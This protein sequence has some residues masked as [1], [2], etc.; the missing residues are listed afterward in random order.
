MAGRRIRAAVAAMLGAGL[1][2]LALTVGLASAHTVSLFI[3]SGKSIS[4][5][6]TTFINNHGN[7]ATGIYESGEE[8]P[9]H[10]SG[11]IAGAD[12]HQQDG[13]LIVFDDGYAYAGNSFEYFQGMLSQFTGSGVP[14]PFTAL[15]QNVNAIVDIPGYTGAIAVDNSGTSTNGNIYIHT[16]DNLV[17]AYDP[18][19]TPLA[20]NFPINFG[21]ESVSGLAVAPD[22]KIWVAIR[23]SSKVV[24]FT[25]GGAPTGVEVN[26]AFSP[27][28]IET[29]GSGNLYVTA[30][31]FGDTVKF[32]SAGT[33]LFKV[34]T[35][36]FSSSVGVDPANGN[37]YIAHGNTISAYKSDGAFIS[38]FGGPDPDHGFN[39]SGNI[40]DIAVN[41]S[42]HSIYVV[43][44][45]G[46]IHIF[47]GTGEI[48]VPDVTTGGAEVTP[49]TATV[50]GTI[51]PDGLDTTD[52]H[53][54]YGPST[55]YNE[56]A[57][58]CIEGKVLSGTGDV[59]V[60]AVLEDLTP[61]T[62]YHYR[63]VSNN[64]NGVTTPGP[65]QTFKPLGPPFISNETVSKVNTDNATLGTEI[66]PR[67]LATTYHFEIGTDTSYG[68]NLPEPD[69][70]LASVSDTER[71][72]QI[73][74]STE[75]TRLKPDTT[76]HFRVVATNEQG[77][78]EGLDHTFHTFPSAEETTDDCPNAHERQQTSAGLLL[79]C[80][81]YEIVSARN[82]GGYDVQSDVILGQGVLTARPD[83]KD[84]VLY[85]LH[86][87]KVPGVSGGPT[88]F[89]L[90]PY[91]A[92]RGSNGWT[93][94]YVG[95]PADETPGAKPFGSPLSGSDEDLNAFA[96]GGPG[97][98]SPCF[99]DGST[100]IPIRM[101]GGGLVQGMK[102]SLDP[103][104]GATQAGFIGQRLSDDGT[105]LVFGSTSKFEEGATAGDVTIYD[106]DLASG[107]THIVSRTPAGATMTGTGNGELAISADGSR[108][109]LGK[110]VSTD[111]FG[112]QRWHPYL[113]V[114]DSNSTIDLAPS[115]TTGVIFSG[116]SADG[117]TVLLRHQGQTR[118][119]R[120]RQQRRSLP[121]RRQRRKRH[122]DP[123]LDRERRRQHR[124]LQPG[125]KLRK[126]HLEQPGRHRVL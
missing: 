83:A 120:H 54:E 110:L 51:N 24:Q 50:H 117:S 102:G 58:T 107:T 108:I 21:G 118:R 34:E 103:G 73:V 1:T 91:V 7:V 69:G 70:A 87:G 53:F 40:V 100:G 90:D 84:R 106:R 55:G 94:R 123:G 121:G 99:P 104:P 125:R 92:T 57:V 126:L 124:C 10:F 46:L 98:C 61:G 27:G 45:Q 31:G 97:L 2:C 6:G 93:T 119:R 32:N 15:T 80:R 111:P 48:T 65:D 30:E 41:G 9:W 39:G 33:E 96:F 109:L 86:F 38:S 16:W 76:Y 26:L 59:P 36:Q 29:D 44:S 77:T 62:T 95:L 20:G 52:C 116:M 105:H 66:D 112:V 22:G 68:L 71:E 88:N 47:Q 14:V 5:K 89:G 81:G 17:R 4:G 101:P 115:T 72:S 64:A 113:N 25:N 3:Y 12:I 85:S 42:D 35:E 122:P 56:G 74:G 75:S 37:V 28:W 60:S 63:L 67:G 8:L 114:N 23:N 82:A 78:T 79:D 19:G 13:N 49:T 11:F 43:D 18:N